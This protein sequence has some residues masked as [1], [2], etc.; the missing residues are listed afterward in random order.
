MNQIEFQ[1]DLDKIARQIMYEDI[2]N[3]DLTCP[4]CGVSPLDYL[5]SELRAFGAYGFF[6]KCKACGLWAHYTLGS[7]PPNFRNE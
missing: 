6:I 4:R 5:F 3:V 7:K 1:K 2:N